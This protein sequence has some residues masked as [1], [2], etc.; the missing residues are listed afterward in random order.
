[1]EGSMKKTIMLGVIVVCVVVAGAI[2]LKTRRRKGPNLEPF[3]DKMTWVKCRN[4]ECGEEYQ[5]N[6]KEY[7]E[8]IQENQDPSTLAPPALTCKK[9]G[10]PSVYRAVK[11]PKCGT[12]F[13]MGS[14]P[15]DFADRCPKCGYSQTEVDRKER[16]KARREGK[17]T[18]AK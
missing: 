17:S 1:M 5:M 13:E 9:C 16:A 12:V 14:I 4:P 8:F 6:L 2:T 18:Q 10:E 7:F 15:H 3:K 11:C